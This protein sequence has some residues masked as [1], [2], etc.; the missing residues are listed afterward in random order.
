MDPRGLCIHDASASSSL[1]SLCWCYKGLFSQRDCT[2]IGPGCL[3]FL[4]DAFDRAS[5][6]A[7]RPCVLIRYSRY[8]SK[9]LLFSYSAARQRRKDLVE[10]LGNTHLLL[11][12]WMCGIRPEF[13]T[14]SARGCPARDSGVRSKRFGIDLFFV[15]LWVLGPAALTYCIIFGLEPSPVSAVPRPSY[16][17]PP[18]YTCLSPWAQWQ[19]QPPLRRNVTGSIPRY[20]HRRLPSPVTPLDLWSSPVSPMN[21]SRHRHSCLRRVAILSVH[22]LFSLHIT[23]QY[24]QKI[25]LISD[26]RHHQEYH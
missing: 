9:G 22:H 4:D 18:A 11:R 10:L 20:L 3:L 16:G 1:I 5:S 14:R 24:H 21:V 8:H 17:F 2:T 7:A 13:S 26:Q 19:P 25:R 23:Q 12:C 6:C 15:L